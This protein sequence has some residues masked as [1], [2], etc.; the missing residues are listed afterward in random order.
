MNENAVSII[1]PAQ[2]EE[3]TISQL[4]QEVKKLDPLEI[5]VVVNGTTD[6]TALVA[7]QSGCT[8]VEFPHSLGND[9]GRA[10][11]AYHAKGDILL[12]LDGDIPVLSEQLEPFLTGVKN[13]YHI[14]L[15]DLSWSA[16][17]PIR[18][19]YTTVSKIVVN[20]MLR[21][22]LNVNSLLAIPHAMSRVALEAIGW[23]NLAD[24]IVAMAIAAEKKLSIGAPGSVDVIRHN[25]VRPVHLGTSENSPFPKA[26]SRILGDHLAAIDYLIKT[27]DPRGGFTDGWRK[28]HFLEK[29]VPPKRRLRVKSS[30]IIPAG[31]ERETIAG[32][33]DSVRAAGVDEII[34]VANGSDRETIEKSIKAGAIVLPFAEPLGHNVARV[35]GAAHS[36]GEIC[37]FVDGDFVILPENLVPFIRAVDSG[38]DVALND[39][40]SLLDIFHPI[41]AISGVKYF[42]NMALKRPDLLN[43][44][45]TAVPHAMHHRVIDTIGYNSLMLPPLAQVQSVLAGFRVE[46][47]HYVDVVTPNRRREEHQLV[48][49]RMPAFDRIFGDHV[50]A[51]NY[52]LSV[53]D[54]RGGFTDGGRD[55]ALLESMKRRT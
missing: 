48:N 28:R 39:L 32:V 8:V 6:G 4:I 15:N 14:A 1:I 53:T 38:V 17:L 55:R 29:Y 43:N 42:L 18:P 40:Q 27:T 16:R 35:I 34:V 5:I 10:V 54:S 22:N 20:Y 2:N 30:A 49:S 47:V 3:N 12:F 51:V 33:I 21:W 46:A 19:H 9:V 44:S 7:K 23:W 50:E 13:G 41:D 45:L 31:E 26:T 52:L 37:L 24:P 36:T 11:G 25:R